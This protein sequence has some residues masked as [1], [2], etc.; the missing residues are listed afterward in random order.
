[1]FT[2][3]L[4]QHGFKVQIACVNLEILRTAQKGESVSVLSQDAIAGGLG[5]TSYHGAV[6]ALSSLPS[7]PSGSASWPSSSSPVF[8]FLESAMGQVVVIIS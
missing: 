1:M 4:S 6:T 8:R 7:T 2:E 3:Q 5:A